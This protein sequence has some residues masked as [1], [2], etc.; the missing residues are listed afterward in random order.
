VARRPLPD[1]I[2]CDNVCYDSLTDNNRC[3]NCIT[4]CSVSE[5][6]VN[7]I[8]QQA[9]TCTVDADCIVPTYI[10]CDSI[11]YDSLTTMDHCGDCTTQCAAPDECM[12]GYCCPP[13][14]C[15]FEIVIARWAFDP[16]IMGWPS[17]T[18]TE[19]A[20]H[21]IAD[22]FTSSDGL[23]TTITSPGPVYWAGEDGW[24]AGD[25]QLIVTVS[26]EAGWFMEFTRIEFDQAMLGISA[27]APDRWELWFASDMSPIGNGTI[28][29][30]FPEFIHE[31][32]TL[33]PGAHDAQAI[34]LWWIA[35][36][37][38]SPGVTWGLDNITI[39]GYV[40]NN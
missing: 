5:T 33:Q 16:N 22:D 40:V 27:D 21:V 35:L 10:C 14:G 19:V 26:T 29:T 38:T 28:T 36:G 8:C 20:T 18:P 2:C 3:G 30:E 7:G 6:C 32:V 24:D 39:Y 13:T 31:T 34:E 1:D 15:G 9:Q 4:Q 11:C 12:S 37:A 23:P 17:R 25:K